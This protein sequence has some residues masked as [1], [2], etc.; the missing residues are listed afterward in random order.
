MCCLLYNACASYVCCL[1]YNACASYVRIFRSLQFELSVE[2]YLIQK[3]CSGLAL[4]LQQE[5][6]D[7]MLVVRLDKMVT[8]VTKVDVMVTKVRWTKW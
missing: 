1:L 3:D 2:D 7:P 8:K 5:G 6:L 4:K